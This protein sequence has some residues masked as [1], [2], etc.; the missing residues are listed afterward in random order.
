M[1]NC[2]LYN[3]CQFV[4]VCLCFMHG[5]RQCPFGLIF[6]YFVIFIFLDE[7]SVEYNSL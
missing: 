1:V 7:Q 5:L 4:Y 6:S 3:L 2:L